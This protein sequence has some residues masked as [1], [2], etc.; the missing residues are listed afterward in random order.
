MREGRRARPRIADDG[1]DR[2]GLEQAIGRR[3]LAGNVK[4]EEAM[5]T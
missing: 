4:M 1:Q 5:A 2:T 3:K